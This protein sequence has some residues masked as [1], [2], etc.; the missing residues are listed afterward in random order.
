MLWKEKGTQRNNLI[1]ARSLVQIFND[2]SKVPKSNEAQLLHKKTEAVK[3]N[4]MSKC[5]KQV[6]ERS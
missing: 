6:A 1:L 3:L 2:F 5:R 4:S